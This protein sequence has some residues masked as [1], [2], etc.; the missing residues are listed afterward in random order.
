M[1]AGFLHYN[2][3]TKSNVYKVG[4]FSMTRKGDTVECKHGNSN[5][6]WTEPLI[7]SLDKTTPM[8]KIMRMSDVVRMKNLS[9]DDLEMEM[10]EH[11][12]FCST[13]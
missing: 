2:M 5:N 8:R 7:D 11:M 9:L 1:G 12:Y 6:P 4:D 13:V 3:F 10:A